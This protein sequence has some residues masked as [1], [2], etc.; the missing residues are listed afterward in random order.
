M[1]TG[2]HFLLGT[3]IAVVGLLLILSGAVVFVGQVADYFETTRWDP[4]SVHDLLRLPLMLDVLERPL[5][6]LGYHAVMPLLDAI[7]AVFLLVVLGGLIVWKA[8]RF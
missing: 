6:W 2:P 1:T 4:Y 3:T 7:P 5:S 8:L